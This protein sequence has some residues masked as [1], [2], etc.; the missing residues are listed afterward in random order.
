MKFLGDSFKGWRI[1]AF[2]VALVFG[3]YE[4]SVDEGDL[5]LV[6]GLG[7]DLDHVVFVLEA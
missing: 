6:A 7:G 3:V 5:V 2:V 1:D 4:A